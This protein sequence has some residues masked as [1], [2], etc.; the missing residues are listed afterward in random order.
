MVKYKWHNLRLKAVRLIS[1]INY[2]EEVQ[3][4]YPLRDDM[5]S[6]HNLE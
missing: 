1:L 5:I 3:T 6:S 4:T 2:I